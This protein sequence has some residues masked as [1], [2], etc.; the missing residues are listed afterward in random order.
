MS[1]ITN[2]QYVTE[3]ACQL[4]V[5]L[6]LEPDGWNP[7]EE[8]KFFPVDQPDIFHPRSQIIRHAPERVIQ[9]N[10]KI[11]WRPLLYEFSRMAFQK[12]QRQ[13]KR[14]QVT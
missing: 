11:K 4:A 1:E 10:Q 13:Q 3:D 12:S 6:L 14:N 8:K 2:S 5:E 9:K 7:A